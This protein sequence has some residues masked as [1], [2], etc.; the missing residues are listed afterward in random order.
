MFSEKKAH[1]RLKLT[2][3]LSYCKLKARLHSDIA[4]HNISPFEPVIKRVNEN[5]IKGKVKC[6]SLTSHLSKQNKTKRLIV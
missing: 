2:Q 1:K 4:L 5:F 3:S 6:D